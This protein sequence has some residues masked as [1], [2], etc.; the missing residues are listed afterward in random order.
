MICL[1][2]PGLCAHNNTDG[3]Q[4]VNISVC[5]FST[6]L[7][8]KTEK[9]AAIS[10]ALVYAFRMIGLFM[11]L[12]IFSLYASHYEAAT[13]LLI[14]LAIGV[15]GLTQGLFQVPFGFVSDRIGRKKVIV[16]GLILFCMGSIVAAL[17][18]NIWQVIAGR[19]LQGMGAIA[20]VVMA[21]AA[22]LTREEVRMRIMA[23]IGMSIG[24]AFMLSMIL[25]PILASQLG[26]SGIFWLTSVLAGI[27]IFIIVFFTPTPGRERFHRDAQLSV[28]DIGTVVRKK[29][30]LRLDFGVFVLHMVLSSTFVLFPLILR[31]QMHIR[32]E[33]HWQTYLS[34]FVL[35]ILVMVP[36]IIYAEK[37]NRMKAM[38]LTGIGIVALAEVGLYLFYGYWPVFAMLVLF[39][40][41]FNFLEASMPSLVAKIAPADLKGTAMGLFST[42]QFLGAFAGGLVGGVMLD[43]H[44]LHVAFLDL[45]WVVVIWWMVAIFMRNPLPVST[46]IVSLANWS[47]DKLNDIEQKLSKLEGVRE[48]SVYPEDDVAYLKIDKKLF[49]DEKLNNL[50]LDPGLVK[51]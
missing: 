12:P 7:M 25:G 2:E 33:D 48:V 24:L 15:Y 28:S 31:D 35:S 18:D 21:L 11:I 22:D 42:S 10:L 34:V 1:G 37:R 27:S 51:A 13:P 16:F 4:H 20:A 8:L 26:I 6:S 17:A 23:V 50:L 46:R 39:F 43:Y 44:Q 29:E 14:G 3:K 5:R 40:S 41:G 49:N 38:F 36:M 9:N 19:A 32:I 47:A 45:G 30:L